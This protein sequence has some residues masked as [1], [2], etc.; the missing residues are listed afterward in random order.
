MKDIKADENLVAKCGLYCGACGAYLK[1][2]C[3]GCAGNEKASWCKPRKC[4]A[5]RK[6]GSCADCADFK[7]YEDCGKLYNFISRAISL[8]T[9]SDRPGSLRRIKEIGRAAYAAEMAAARAHA[10]K[11]KAG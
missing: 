1:G 11:R 3:P 5:E 6:Y 2:R 9:G 10:V 8:F 7:A 4:C